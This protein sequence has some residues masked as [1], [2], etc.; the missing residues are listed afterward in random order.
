MA[1]LLSISVGEMSIWMNCFGLP[2]VLPL[3]CDS[4]QF[5]RAP[6][7][8]TTSAS[9][10]TYERAAEADCGCVSGSRPLAI[11]IGRYGM[12]VFSTSARIS[13]SA[14]AYAAPLP[15]RISGRLA[16]FSSATA[17]SIESGAGS[18]RGAGS[19]TLI[20]DL[21]PRS[22]SIDWPSRLA[23]RSRY[24]PPGRPDTAARM[25]RAIPTPMSSACS[26]RKAALACGRA[27]ASWSISS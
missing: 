11:D 13:A 24:T 2:Q 18:W 9:A 15:N 22:A 10:S 27:I 12:P 23:G 19:T 17:R 14:R 1:T 8:I 16:L 20:N 26:T 6:T 7:S 4:S 25:A 5:R 3:P 21:R